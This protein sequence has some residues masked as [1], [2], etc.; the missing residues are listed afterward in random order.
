MRADAYAIDYKSHCRPLKALAGLAIHAGKPD[1]Y[2]CKQDL[3]PLNT[4]FNFAVT[5]PV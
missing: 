5:D 1:A 3:D 2:L 4:V